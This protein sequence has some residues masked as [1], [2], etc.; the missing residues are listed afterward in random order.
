[1]RIFRLLLVLALAAF[2]V[3]AFL[4]HW[5]LADGAPRNSLQMFLD[6][7]AHRPFAYRLLAPS[8]VKSIEAAMPDATRSL[9]ANDVAPTL[10]AQYVEPLLKIYE[11]RIPGIT[12]RAHQDWERERYRSSFVVMVALMF[13][14]LAAA[15]L[16]VHRAATL[17]GANELAATGA[18]VAYGLVV[19]TMFLNGG[20]FYDFTEQLGAM[21]FICCIYQ[22]KWW[23]SGVVLFL[24]Q[25]NKETALL[26]PFFMLPHIWKASR[27]QGLRWVM[28]NLLICISLLVLVRLY[29]ADL[30]GQASEWHL[31]TNLNFW[32]SP[33][34][35]QRTADFYA[36]GIELPRIT[37]LLF[38][39]SALAI[40]WRRGDTANVMGATMAFF[41]LAVLLF[42]MG[43][44]DEF[45]NISLALPLLVL[46]LFEQRNQKGAK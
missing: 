37:F 15:I 44:T 46:L 24:M 36:V 40:G 14:S 43:Y 17:L 18:M 21:A 31:Q 33:A 35:W 4:S 38:S 2:D 10:R 19:P 32:L 3:S 6:G 30:P 45:R 9:L 34:S 8:V 22:R 13:L 39:L 29:V 20:Y 28:A 1:M 11:P 42:T 7:Q 41:V 23:L 5:S 25:I 12:A 27:W 16:L 26:L